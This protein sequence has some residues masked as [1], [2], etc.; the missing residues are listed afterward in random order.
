MLNRQRE[1]IQTLIQANKLLTSHFQGVFDL[2]QLPIKDIKAL[3]PGFPLK[4]IAHT[5]YAFEALAA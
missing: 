2:R 3:E 1:L 5:I 4:K